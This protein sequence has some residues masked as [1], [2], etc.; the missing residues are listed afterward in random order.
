METEKKNVLDYLRNKQKAAEIEAKVNGINLWV[1]LGAIAFVLWKL[2]DYLGSTIW[3]QEALILRTLVITQAVF[4]INWIARPSRGIRDEVRY[5]SIRDIDVPFVRLFECLLLLVPS[6]LFLYRVEISVSVSFLGLFGVLLTVIVVTTIFEKLSAKHFDHEKKFPEPRFGLTT[7]SD[8]KSD[9]ILIGLL[10]WTIV[11]HAWRLYNQVDSISVE[12]AKALALISAFYLLLLIATRRRLS[13]HANDWL[14]ELETD[15]V[16][17]VVSSDVALSRIENR[18]LGPRL[19]DVMDKFLD[20]VE[21]KFSGLA[22]ALEGCQRDLMT[23]C[24]VPVDY[25]AERAARIQAAAAESKLYIEKLSKDIDE[26]NEYVQKLAARNTKTPRQDLGALLESLK[27]R[28]AIYEGRVAK[29]K[30]E[31]NSMITAAKARQV[32]TVQKG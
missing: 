23:V 27:A 12:S 18:A 19:K 13:S 25:Q 9:V 32:P 16:L 6:A 10:V 20:D 31:L 24:E 7:K 1:L 15:V 21:R 22:S 14:Y 11:D 2:L 17:N 26:F 8:L 3:S 4:L 28:G 5:M 30:E 29:S